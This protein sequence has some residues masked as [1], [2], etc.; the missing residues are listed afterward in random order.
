MPSMECAKCGVVKAV[1][2]ARKFFLTSKYYCSDTCRDSAGPRPIM[3]GKYIAVY[4]PKHRRW[5]Q[6]HRLL[7]EQALGR[8]LKRNEVVHHIDGN[9]LNNKPSNLM[10]CY[11]WYHAELHD[12]ME[13]A[14]I[15]EHITDKAST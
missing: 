13:K 12:K 7:A 10:V 15:R 4:S 6:E 9:K 2:S 5:V 11:D 8:P 14:W 3:R 1:S